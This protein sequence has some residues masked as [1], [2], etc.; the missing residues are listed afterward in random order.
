MRYQ[1]YAPSGKLEKFIKCYWFL[2]DDAISPARLKERVFPDGCIELIFHY[3]D[4]YRKYNHNNQAEL[5]PRSF[6]HGQLKKF[7][8]LEATGKTG[9]FSVRFQPAGLHPFVHSEVNRFTGITVPISEIW[10]ITGTTLETKIISAE[11]HQERIDIIEQFLLAHFITRNSYDDIAYCVGKIVDH[12]GNISIDEL[13]GLLHTGTRSLE[14]K[15]TAT[16]GLSPKLL[17]RII[18]FNQTLQRIEARDFS[19][20]TCVAYEGGFYDQAHFIKD[21]KQLTGL[22]PK[23]YFSE[24]LEMVKFFNLD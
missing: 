4:L 2:E 5:Q 21:F 11:S 12:A 6:V 19:N 23:Q 8:E 13:A 16:V 14:R 17:A 1:E 24:N 20:F 15:F 3:G 9:I 18:R 10:P 22:N 7:M